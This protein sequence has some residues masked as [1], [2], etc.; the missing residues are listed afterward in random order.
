[1]SVDNVQIDP[2]V[3]ELFNQFRQGRIGKRH[4]AILLDKPDAVLALEEVQDQLSE[5]R[6]QSFAVESAQPF[7]QSVWDELLGSG[8]VTVPPVPKLTAKQVKS[9]ERFGFLLMYLPGITE[10]EY[11]AGFVKPN[12]SAC[13]DVSQIERKPLTGQWIAMETIKKPDLV[14]PIG[15]PDDRLMATLK[16]TTRFNTSYYDLIGGLIQKIAKVTG[17]PKKGTRLPSAEEWNLVG[18]LFNW[19]YEHRSMPHLPD[20]GSTCSVERCGNA[21]CS[22]SQL[23]VGNVESGRL[24]C[25][26]YDWH[27]GRYSGI[28][29]RVLAVL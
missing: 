22:V 29:F 4:I 15:Y 18:N 19:L 10:D 17:F 21:Y 7:W 25:V 26:G 5:T 23:I 28:A 27:D 16:R 20:L 13:L 9:M 3:H 8:K 14:D 6:Q 24:A 12:W 11:P 1:M 2:I